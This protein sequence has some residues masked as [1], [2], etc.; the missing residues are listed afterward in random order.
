MRRYRHSMRRCR[1]TAW[2]PR[3]VTDERGDIGAEFSVNAVLVGV[4][5]T[6]QMSN[7]V[8]NHGDMGTFSKQDQVGN[9]HS[10]VGNRLSERLGFVG[11]V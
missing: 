4:G 8:T 3:G 2:Q 7:R 6:P 1:R 11:N 10:D 9:R 5:V